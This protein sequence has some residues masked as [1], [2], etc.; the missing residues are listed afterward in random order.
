MKG[1]AIKKPPLKRVV[2]YYITIGL[3]TKARQCVLLNQILS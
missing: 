2:L 3:S 1:I